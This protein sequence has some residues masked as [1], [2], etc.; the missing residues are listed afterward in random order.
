MKMPKPL[1]HNHANLISMEI[2]QMLP[3]LFILAEAGMVA[4]RESLI[5]ARVTIPD[6]TMAI[7]APLRVRTSD[8]AARLHPSSYV[9]KSQVLKHGGVAVENGLVVVVAVQIH[10]RKFIRH[11][12]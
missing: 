12:C 7:R 9:M 3:H 10:A 1:T 6:I 8:E 4:S 5:R 2:F 11:E